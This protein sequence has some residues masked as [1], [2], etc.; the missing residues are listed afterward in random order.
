MEKT[1]PSY[2]STQARAQFCHG[3][4]PPLLSVPQ[5][6]WTPWRRAQASLEG[7]I[8]YLFIFQRNKFL[9]VLTIPFT[10]GTLGLVRKIHILP[11]V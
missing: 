10:Q 7:Y 6:S 1:R 2:Y 11:S 9:A 3:S 8:L 5:G 4:T